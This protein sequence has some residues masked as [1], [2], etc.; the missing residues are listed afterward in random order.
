MILVNEEGNSEIPI[1]RD[2]TCGMF[3]FKLGVVVVLFISF[4]YRVQ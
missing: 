2:Y 1:D 4:W 3:C